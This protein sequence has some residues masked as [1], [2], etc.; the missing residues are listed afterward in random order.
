[1]YDADGGITYRRSE[2]GSLNVELPVLVIS[3]LK[4]RKHISGPKN[5]ENGS[6]IWHESPKSKKAPGASGCIPRSGLVIRRI[7]DRDPRM[8]YLS[9][10]Q[11]GG[12]ACT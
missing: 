10:N 3:Y 6:R 4:T 9:L 1:M 11:L 5:K 2:A 7:A 12:E 8:D